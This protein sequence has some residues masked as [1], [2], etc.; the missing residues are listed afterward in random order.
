MGAVFLKSITGKRL[1]SNEKWELPL[2]DYIARRHGKMSNRITVR[3]EVSLRC[4][5]STETL[6]DAKRVCMRKDESYQGKINSL[7][8]E[9]VRNTLPIQNILVPGTSIECKSEQ[10]CRVTYITGLSIKS[11]QMMQRSINAEVYWSPTWGELKAIMKQDEMINE[12][13]D[14]RSNYIQLSD[15]HGVALGIK[16]QNTG[17]P[18]CRNSGMSIYFLPTYEG[19]FCLN[20]SV[21]SRHGQFKDSVEAKSLRCNEAWEVPVTEN[22]AKK[23]SKNLNIRL[24][25]KLE[26]Q[27]QNSIQKL[28]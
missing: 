26:Y 20:L 9:N 23:P 7:A 13:T 2:N 19:I 12:T 24:S 1:N 22:V 18:G 14:I 5:N 3:C 4:Q 21:D 11:C 15:F 6:N 8:S 28:G 25:I 17:A 10:K 16:S 27:G